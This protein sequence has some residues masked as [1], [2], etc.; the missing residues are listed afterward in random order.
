MGVEDLSEIEQLINGSS[1]GLTETDITGLLSQMFLWILLPSI[2]FSTVFLVLYI[3]HS[4]RRRKL[5]NAIF[6]IRDIL[7]DMN[8]SNA[9]A[10]PAPSTI[11][12][13]SSAEQPEHENTTQNT[14]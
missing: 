11:P 12:V 2:I 10:S 3:V 6:E 9:A 13:A 8:T 14:K 7:R 4:I 1:T 5:E